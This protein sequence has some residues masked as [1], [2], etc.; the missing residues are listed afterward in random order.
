MSFDSEDLVEGGVEEVGGGSARGGDPSFQCVAPAH[1]LVH[2]R[3]NPLLLGERRNG[4]PILFH[5][6]RRQVR[7]SRTVV[8]LSNLLTAQRAGKKAVREF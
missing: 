7:L 8:E 1:Q 5:A 4:Y 6:V 3:H 2:L